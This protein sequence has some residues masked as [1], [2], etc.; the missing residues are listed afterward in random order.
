MRG[1]TKKVLFLAALFGSM[2]LCGCGANTDGDD[3]VLQLSG[4]AQAGTAKSETDKSETAVQAVSS[5]ALGNDSNMTEVSEPQTCYVYICGAVMNPGVY[6]LGAG[7]RLYEVVELAGGL[8]DEADQT[9][10]NLAR[11]VTDGEQVVILTREETAKLEAEGKYVPGQLASDAAV[12]SASSLVNI[13]TATL[14]EL[15][16]VSGIGETRAQ[17]IIAY[18]EANGSFGCIEDIMK[19]DGI[20][21]GLFAKIK[22]QI[23]I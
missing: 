13:N 5:D 11:Q 4:D 21:E 12:M 17:A 1:M 23:T 14:S 8:T 22:D 18:R 9:S 19:V 20:K 7:S 2:L 16:S 15:T 6:E 3:I 10:L